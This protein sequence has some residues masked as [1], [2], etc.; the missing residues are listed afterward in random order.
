MKPLGYSDTKLVCL[1]GT[2]RI[3]SMSFLV[4]L[5]FLLARYFR[6]HLI[7]K[8]VRIITVITSRIVSRDSQ[9][10]ELL[11]MLSSPRLVV[12]S[13][14]PTCRIRQENKMRNRMFVEVTVGLS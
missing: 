5:C 10:M 7:T 4:L 6:T 13:S 14:L 9:D 1:A 2:G 8:M 11:D 12:F 3:K